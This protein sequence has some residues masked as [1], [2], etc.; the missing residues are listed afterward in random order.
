[1]E[2]Q[3][4]LQDFRVNILAGIVLDA[5]GCKRADELHGLSVLITTLIKA[6][7]AGIQVIVAGEGTLELSQSIQ[8]STFLVQPSTRC[9]AQFCSILGST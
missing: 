9:T 8:R 1:M 6:G 3:S 7:Q 5:E 4:I 2:D